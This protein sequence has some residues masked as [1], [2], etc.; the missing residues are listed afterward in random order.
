[1]RAL[2]EHG[3]DP[4]YQARDAGTVLDVVTATRGQEKNPEAARALDDVAA[5]LREW[6]QRK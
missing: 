6:E 1:V 3:A 4:A 2:L 5:V